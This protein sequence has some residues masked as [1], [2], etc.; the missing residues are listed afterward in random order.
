MSLRVE[1]E[2]Y[3]DI[4]NN[5]VNKCCIFPSLFQGYMYVPINTSS[6]LNDDPVPLEHK[7]VILE[8]IGSM[9]NLRIAGHIIN[10]TFSVSDFRSS[11]E[12]V[13]FLQ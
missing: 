11:A 12:S 5:T 6:I 4:I 7:H 1:L 9:C 3:R 13:Y 8:Y 10:I 2:G